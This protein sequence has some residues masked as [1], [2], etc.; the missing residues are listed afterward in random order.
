MI[1]FVVAITLFGA[2]RAT[3]STC[4]TVS[5][6]IEEIRLG[7]VAAIAI[8][9]APNGQLRMKPCITSVGAGLFVL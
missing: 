7:L 2:D 8:N 5:E 3:D 4:P 6:I 1:R 9:T